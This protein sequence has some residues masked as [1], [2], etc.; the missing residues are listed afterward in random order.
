MDAKLKKSLAKLNTPWKIQEAITQIPYN[1][2]NY[3]RSAERV[4]RDH[5]AHCFE[6]ALLACL[7][8]EQLGHPP[9]MLHFRSYRDD[10]HVVAIFLEKGKWGAVGKSNTTLLSW[11]TPVYQTIDE[12]AMSYFPFYFNT[13][14]QLSLVSWAAPIPLSKYEKKW[15]W[16]NGEGDVSEMSADFY[17]ERAH[18]VLSEKELKKLP[19]AT[20]KLVAACFLGANV[21]GLYKA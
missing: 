3:S 15:Q 2:E 5:S 17:R 19:R 12:L 6:G 11:R 13:K 7:A 20:S 14:G 8:L 4:L 1:P 21:D 18:K 10:D 9:Q 16:R